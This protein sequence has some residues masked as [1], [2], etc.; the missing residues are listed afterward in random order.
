MDKAKRARTAETPKQ[1]SLGLMLRA[2]CLYPDLAA[3]ASALWDIAAVGAVF[4]CTHLREH[5]RCLSRVGGILG[6]RP[7]SRAPAVLDWSINRPIIGI[8]T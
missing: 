5:V 4:V 2:P 1:P 8:C 3:V 7:G 6:H